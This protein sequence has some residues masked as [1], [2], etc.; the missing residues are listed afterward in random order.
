MPHR[1]KEPSPWAHKAEYTE[2]KQLNVPEKYEA[3]MGVA[4]L[5]VELMHTTINMQG[6]GGLVSSKSG[7][8]IIMQG[9]D[10]KK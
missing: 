6:A 2:R 7:R 5:K 9:R 4:T 1:R 3:V 10:E 8:L